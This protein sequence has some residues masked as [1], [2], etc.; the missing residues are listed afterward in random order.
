[1]LG[2]GSWLPRRQPPESLPHSL[3]NGL[4]FMKDSET[5]VN[6]SFILSR[7]QRREGRGVSVPMSIVFSALFK[8]QKLLR[9]PNIYF[10][11]GEKNPH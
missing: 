2:E 1:M 10:S 8:G 11:G 9:Y 7:N 4:G 5:Q 3:Q 6:V